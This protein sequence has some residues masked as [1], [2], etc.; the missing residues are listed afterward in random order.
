MMAWVRS[1]WNETGEIDR[2]VDSRLVEE[3]SNF[4]HREQ[5]KQVLLV[6]L[7]CTEKEPNRRPRMRDIVDHL[8]DSKTSHY[9]KH[10]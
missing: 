8:I 10:G 3:L 7:R 6:A 1:V 4:D 9:S 2:I 5:M